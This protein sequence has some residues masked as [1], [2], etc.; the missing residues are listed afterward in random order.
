MQVQA[1][2]E[3]RAWQRQVWGA[4]LSWGAEA[5][6]DLQ[7]RILPDYRHKNSGEI[8]KAATPYPVHADVAQGLAEA[9]KAGLL[10]GP[11]WTRW[12]AARDGRPLLHI[13]EG[14][15]LTGGLK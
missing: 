6:K 3:G 2:T 11:V 7:S 13:W 10:T 14:I 4:A 1:E 5:P 9:M 15:A 8:R 12:P